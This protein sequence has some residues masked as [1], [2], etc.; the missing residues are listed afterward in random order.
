MKDWIATDL[1]S[2]LFHRSWEA[3]GAVPATWHPAEDGGDSRP[4][5]W[6]RDGT[7][8]ML[9]ALGRSFTLVPVTARDMGSFSRVRV[10]GLQLAGPAV[11]A[12]GAVILDSKGN[13][14]ALWEQCMVELLSHWEVELKQLCE[15]LIARSAGKARP[16]LVVGPANLPAYLVAKAEEGW[17][18]SSEGR[19]ILDGHDWSGCRVGVLGTELQ[20]LPPGVGKREAVAEVRD[21]YFGGMPPAMC[22]GDMPQDLDFMRLGELMAMPLGSDLEKSLL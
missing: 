14:D 5:S 2:T 21:R 22:M 16:R 20:V 3:T 9:K 6:M 19:A 10:A 1:D 4:S 15:W 8:R 7:F 12:N 11:I 17:W 18:S 13:P